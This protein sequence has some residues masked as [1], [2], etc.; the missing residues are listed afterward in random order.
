MCMGV[1]VSKNVA[2]YA[3]MKGGRGV[4]CLYVCVFMSV[5]VQVWCSSDGKVVECYFP[6]FK[7]ILSGYSTL[8]LWDRK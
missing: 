7:F 8:L 5:V 2:P 4:L 1:C 3:C 6:A